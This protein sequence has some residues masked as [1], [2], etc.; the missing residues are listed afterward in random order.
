[1]IRATW[2]DTMKFMMPRVTL[3][4]GRLSLEKPVRSK[5]AENEVPVAALAEDG[6][7]WKKKPV[8]A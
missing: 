6:F 7:Y 8:P 5:Q 4:R 3:R 2:A 1:M